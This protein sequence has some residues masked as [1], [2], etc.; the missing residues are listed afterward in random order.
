[1]DENKPVVIP[2]DEI[3]A[4]ATQSGVT[5]MKDEKVLIAGD[6]QRARLHRYIMAV[7]AIVSIVTVIGIP[8]LPLVWAISR[9]YVRK[10]GYWV[11][12]SRVI[13]TNGIIGFRTRSIPLERVS[14]VAISCSFLEKWMG[15]KSV[16]VR[17]MT[18]EAM[19][20]A[21]MFAA[22]DATA[23]QHKILDQV[24]AVN[25]RASDESAGALMERPYR[26]SSAQTSEMMEVLRRIEA[27]TRS[28]E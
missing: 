4:L 9:A 7:A 20:G 23:L 28:R 27:N 15:L 5:L 3:A 11:T 18:G 6:P 26:D 13:V 22:K 17:D 10:H 2:A 8:F 21:S 1:M 25:R 19:S 14:D 16:I 24:H 12:D